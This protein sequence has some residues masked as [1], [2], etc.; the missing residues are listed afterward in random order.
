MKFFKKIVKETQKVITAPIAAV[1]AVVG[2]AVGIVSIPFIYAYRGM[3][4]AEAMACGK[5]RTLPPELQQLLQKHYNVDLSSVRYAVSIDTKHGQA[6]TLENEIFFPRDINLK[7]TGDLKWMLHELEHVRQY[8]VHGGLEPFIIKYFVNAGL[9]I[10]RHGSF[11]IHDN[12]NLERE[13]DDKANSIIDQISEQ[14][15]SECAMRR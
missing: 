1:T 8:K 7:D 14:Y 5:W 13:A 10:G 12:I 11:N 6:I 4:Q 15:I 9:E 3:M 2:G